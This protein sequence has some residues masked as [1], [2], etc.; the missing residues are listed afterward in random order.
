MKIIDLDEIKNKKNEELEEVYKE[1]IKD[2]YDDYLRSKIFLYIKTYEIEM[3]DSDIEFI[4]NVDF[5]ILFNFIY[6]DCLH[7]LSIHKKDKI[8]FNEPSTIVQDIDL[9]L[10][11]LIPDILDHLKERYENKLE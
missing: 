9:I 1:A 10:N 4:S 5:D 8:L 6:L 11:S 7:A 2:A 3:S